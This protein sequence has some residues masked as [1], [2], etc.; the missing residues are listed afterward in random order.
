M[1]GA[2]KGASTRHVSP[3][4]AAIKHGNINA[5]RT[6]L[7]QPDVQ[8]NALVSGLTALACCVIEGNLDSAKI[9][10]THPECD[11]NQVVN[12]VTALH[13]A[14]YV[15]HAEMVEFLISRGRE[16]FWDRRHFWHGD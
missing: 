16:R 8:V 2:G 7:E 1:I 4:I 13:L 15:C 9:L 5:M 12:G 3:L 11:I 6:I 10:L 14:R